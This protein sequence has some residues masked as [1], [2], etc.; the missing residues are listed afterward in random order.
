MTNEEFNR[1]VNFIVAQQAQFAI[2]IGQLRET[3][4]QFAIDM[5]QLR[6]S[7]AQTEK[8]VAESAQVVNRL[9]RVTLV[10]FTEVNAKINAL[11]DAQIRT[12]EA[13]RRTEEAQQRTQEAQQRTEE[14]LKKLIDRDR[15][16]DNG[17][18]N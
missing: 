14:A 17:T 3:Q 6:E 15:S 18:N 12:E 11:V 2:D 4:A 8:F 13:H 7:Q 10:G 9:A 16:K 5:G 1:Q